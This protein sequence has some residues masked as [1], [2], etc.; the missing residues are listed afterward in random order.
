MGLPKSVSCTCSPTERASPVG[1]I[2]PYVFRQEVAECAFPDNHFQVVVLWHVL[3]HLRDP[4]AL[5]RE[6]H[7][8]LA[9]GGWLS[10]AVPNLGGAQAQAS[11]SHWF[12]LDVP[13]HFWHFRPRSLQYLLERHG[14]QLI[15]W[16]TLSFEYDWFGTVQSWMNYALDDRNRLYSLLKR[17][18]PQPALEWIVRVAAAS[19]LALPALASALW[20]AACGQGGTLTLLAQKPFK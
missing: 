7:R 3:E 12:H 14:F 4:R 13:R 17:E 2:L 8:I 15:S 9:P 5:L 11:G 10:L 19:A 20:D 1:H 18:A 16:K 6:I